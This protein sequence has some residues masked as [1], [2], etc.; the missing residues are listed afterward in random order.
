[1][2]VGQRQATPPVATV[3]RLVD[4]V[5]TFEQTL[6]NPDPTR[7]FGGRV[8]TDGETIAV[9]IGGLQGVA[10]SVQVYRQ[11]TG[12]VWV[13]DIR[14]EGCPGGQNALFDFAVRGDLL[15]A[16][17][18][19]DDRVHVYRRVGGVW[20]LEAFL[21][22]TGGS[23]IQYFGNVLA[24][25]GDRIFVGAPL[26]DP[27]GTAYMFRYAPSAP[28]LPTP[29]C[30]AMNQGKWQQKLRLVPSGASGYGPLATNAAGT[31]L[32]IGDRFVAHLFEVSAGVWSETRQFAPYPAD[33]VHSVHF[34]GR[35]AD[36]DEVAMVNGSIFAELSSGWDQ[37]DAVGA[38]QM[39]VAATAVFQL[40]TNIVNVY[41]LDPVCLAE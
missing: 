1:M 21:T 9:G 31:R 7:D 11:D 5:W 16:G 23:S 32:L 33:D 22:P 36:A 14:I 2:V 27:G 25:G 20:Q 26:D 35:G 37:I 13:E 4:G 39:D 18:V 34:G 30:D 19:F 28:Q 6:S 3:Y 40:A 10:G 12:G 17:E 29:T 24:V 8:A 38:G 41:S 15:V